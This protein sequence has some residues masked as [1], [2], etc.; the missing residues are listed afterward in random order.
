MWIRGIK[1]T[2]TGRLPEGSKTKNRPEGGH[3][4]FYYINLILYLYDA[5]EKI[6]A[7]LESG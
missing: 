2:A 3:H 5:T 7:D 6:P 1:K 4:S